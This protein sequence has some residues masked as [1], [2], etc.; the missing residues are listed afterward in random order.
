MNNLVKLRVVH[1]TATGTKVPERK[2]A[3]LV[4]HAT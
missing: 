1:D 4:S 2:E 3:V